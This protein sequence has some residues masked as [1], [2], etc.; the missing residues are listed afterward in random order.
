MAAKTGLKQQCPSCE[1]IIPIK[2]E[3]LI[4]KK[5][6]CPKCGE[7]FRVEDQDADSNPAKDLKAARGTGNG[8]GVPA[9]TK[10]GAKRRDEDEDEDRPKF[11]K[12]S[13]A[14]EGN[15][16]KLILGLGLAGVAV[17][18]LGVAGYFIFFHNS[19]PKRGSGTPV[20]NRNTNTPPGF[21]EGTSETTETT[22][23]ENVQ[24]VV[25]FTG[26]ALSNMLP[27]ETQA[28]MNLP[29]PELLNN[30]LGG[31]ALNHPAV[32]RA[33]GIPVGSIEQVIVAARY[34]DPMWIFAIMR[35]KE[36]VKLEA[37]K[38]VLRL[39]PAEG[40]PILGQD[41]FSADFTWF[42]LVK[43][44]A[45]DNYKPYFNAVTPVMVRQHD[46]QTVVFADVM[47]MKKF[48]NDK[49]QPPIQE[50]KPPD[51]NEA[52][53][54]PFGRGGPGRRGSQ[55]N[56]PG[57]GGLPGATPSPEPTPVASNSYRT[58][59]PRIKAMMDQMETN[60]PFLVSAAVDMHPDEDTLKAMLEQGATPRSAMG[61]SFKWAKEKMTGV[62]GIEL[63]NDQEAANAK[64]EFDD[65]IKAWA[66]ITRLIVGAGVPVIKIKLPGNDAS[67]GGPGSSGGGF[68]GPGRRQPG[69]LPGGPGPGV[70]GPGIRPGRPGPGPLPGQPGQPGQPGD[71]DKPNPTEA[72]ADITLT[73]DVQLKGKMVLTT[74][75]IQLEQK[76][77]DNLFQIA[78]P[79]LIRVQG[80]LE[81][82]TT[83]PNPHKL[84]SGGVAYSE[85]EKQ[86]PRGVYDRKAS[87][88]RAKRAWP[89]DE[90]V[91]WMAELLP[92]LGHEDLH[93][94]ID[95][96]LSWRDPENLDAAT[97]LVPEFLS[98]HSA[99]DTWYTKYPGIDNEATS[100]HLGRLMKAIYGDSMG[101]IDKVIASTHFV[102]I[103]GIGLDAASYRLGDAA[104]AEKMGVFGYN[105]VTRLGDIGN[106]SKTAFMIQVP[107][108][109]RT[110]WLAGGG[111]TIRGV[112]ETKSVQPF[113][114]QRSEGK[115]STMMIMT[116]GSVRV[117][118]E[119]ISD[120]VF[121]D[122]C[123]IKG[124][125][126]D[127]DI[128]RIAPL[129]PPT[130]Q[131]ELKTVA[132]APPSPAKPEEKKPASAPPTKNE[133]AKIPPGK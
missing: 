121:K 109:Y 42:D 132:T 122:L 48:L 80:E 38:S 113:L 73:P 26:G 66:D 116:D 31:L 56:L 29:M 120:Q 8:K 124:Q 129:V 97:S 40:G 62:A 105:R 13:K 131:P 12:K 101:G 41:Y 7:P 58:V 85:K 18:L 127:I 95:F 125:K 72:P 43:M 98:A 110:P 106:L 5:I 114:S 21:G 102:G 88:A 45:P 74:V 32:S 51:P 6:K 10:P 25:G 119:N 94:K 50:A 53:Q 75:D 96:K 71:P 64:K 14:G 16:N 89:P 100:T 57:G 112:P 30:S 92:Y 3:G 11:K 128:D 91:S 20:A 15:S 22:K 118:S 4:G 84:G 79:Y 130:K 63:V 87:A 65:A 9:K 82:A 46:P 24:P 55:S 1:A 60:A 36:P 70:P 90:R 78:A 35:T 76:I 93:G 86:F 19:E 34:T 59:H 2:D 23:I 17:A 52:N 37:L 126:S 108:I 33:L 104:V 111:S 39:K 54:N 27:S 123:R 107:P 133:D 77:F 44:F 68:P 49:G 67:P 99:R 117:I 115:R 69:N 103:G 83:K 28:V 81:M 61:F 47:P